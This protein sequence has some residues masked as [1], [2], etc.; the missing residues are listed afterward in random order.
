MDFLKDKFGFLNTKKG[1]F[2]FYFFCGNSYWILDTH[3]IKKKPVRL[4][5]EFLVYCC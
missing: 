1:Y 5:S 3:N 4:Y 2:F